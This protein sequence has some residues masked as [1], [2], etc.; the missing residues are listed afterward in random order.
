MRDH[1][2]LTCPVKNCRIHI[3]GQI[4]C[5]CH[6][7][8]SIQVNVVL[9]SVCSLFDSGRYIAED[10]L[11]S[12]TVRLKHI[13]MKSQHTMSPL[14]SPFV[15]S[16]SW[17]SISWRSPIFV[18]VA[19][20]DK[21]QKI[22][23]DEKLDLTQGKPDAHFVSKQQLR[24]IASDCMLFLISK[25]IRQCCLCK[26]GSSLC[27]IDS[28]REHVPRNYKIVLFSVLFRNLKSSCTCVRK[29][30]QSTF[31]RDLRRKALK[32]G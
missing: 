25:H 15:S 6:L 9:V 4:S 8:V 2:S 11:V 27:W 26:P 22:I 1:A 29:I 3:P 10:D 7:D 5:H 21:P 18:Y 17:A 31:C 32:L 24:N 16:T 13:E 23:T 30:S 14:P 19:G 12:K 20:L 28:G